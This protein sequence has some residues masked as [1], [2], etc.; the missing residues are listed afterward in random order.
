MTL[1]PEPKDLTKAWDEYLNMRKK[2]KKPLTPYG[3]ELAKKRLA[4]LSRGDIG[5]AIEI[6][7]N[8]IVN[9]YQ[10]LFLPPERKSSNNVDNA[11]QD[12]FK[13]YTK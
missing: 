12:L 8:S 4:D 7:E 6:L 9:S 11:V 3:E 1:F 13:Q 2:I 10:G 5:L